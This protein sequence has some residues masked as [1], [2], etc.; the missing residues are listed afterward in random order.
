M[1]YKTKKRRT[2][3]FSIHLGAYDLGMKEGGKKF[4][5]MGTSPFVDY[6]FCTFWRAQER[7]EELKKRENN[8]TKKK[9]K[10]KLDF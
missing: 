8:T 1:K 9:K 4:W 2:R 5:E 10:T 3:T 6:R 7:S